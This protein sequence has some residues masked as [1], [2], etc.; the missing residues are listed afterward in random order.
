MK[1]CVVIKNA[2]R[3]GNSIF[4][5]RA[6]VLARAIRADHAGISC[7]RDFVVSLRHPEFSK[8]QPRRLGRNSVVMRR[9]WTLVSLL[10]FFV[11]S[12]VGCGGAERPEMGYCTGKV[13]T[14]DGKPVAN[15]VVVVKPGDGRAAMDVTN[16]DG[17]F[18]IEYTAG[19][20]GTKV[21]PSTIGFEWPLG[22]AAPFAIEAKY[23]QGRSTEKIDIKSGN[24]EFNYV[25]EGTGPPPVGIVD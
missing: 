10:L 6:V 11:V 4:F 2:F 1:S 19:E 12:F 16:E 9:M 21:G 18:D 23:I 8:F 15:L 20:R 5:R 13:T 17:E 7:G 3:S 25:L 14:K 24:N 22:Y